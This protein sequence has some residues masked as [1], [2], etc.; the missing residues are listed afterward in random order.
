MRLKA[1]SDKIYND[2]KTKFLELLSYEVKRCHILQFVTPDP[3]WDGPYH[4]PVP[5]N[6]SKDNI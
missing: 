6:Y 3:T 4:Q 1:E 2:G 5:I